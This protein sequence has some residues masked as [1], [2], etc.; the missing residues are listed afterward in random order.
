MIHPKTIADL[1]TATRG[2]L[3]LSFVWLGLFDSVLQRELAPETAAASDTT[4]RQT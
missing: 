4:K 3:A 1:I 2:L